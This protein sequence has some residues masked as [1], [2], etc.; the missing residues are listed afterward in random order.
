M[1]KLENL[2][3]RPIKIYGYE[4][5]KNK[6]SVI[7]ADFLF[8]LSDDSGNA[9]VFMVLTASEGHVSCCSIFE[10]GDIDFTRRQKRYALLLQKKTVISS[11]KSVVRVYN[12]AYAD[13]IH[14]SPAQ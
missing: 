13:K 4:P 8:V 12:N 1:H 10:E 11:G 5:R 9:F 14:A 7:H 2:F 3:D 6:L